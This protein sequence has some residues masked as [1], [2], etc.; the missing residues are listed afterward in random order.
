M[1]VLGDLGTVIGRAF[2]LLVTGLLNGL[3]GLYAWLVGISNQARKVLDPWVM[4]L[5]KDL[6]NQLTA[7]FLEGSPPE[8]IEKAVEEYYKQLQRRLKKVAEEIEQKSGGCG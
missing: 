7:G 5:T 8:E 2:G 1:G 4:Q 3:K 6:Y